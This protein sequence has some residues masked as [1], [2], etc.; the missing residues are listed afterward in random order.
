MLGA[1][2]WK[3]GEAI[4]FLRILTGIRPAWNPESGVSSAFIEKPE[5]FL[6]CS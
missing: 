1:L 6:L 5:S 3:D 4:E 2:E